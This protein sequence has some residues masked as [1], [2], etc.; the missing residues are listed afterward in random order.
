[1]KNATL[2][3]TLTPELRRFVEGKV[4][5]GR[6][7]DA[8]EVIR[9][10]LRKFEQGSDHCEDPS[11]EKLIKEGLDSG[12]AEPLNRRAWSQIWAESDRLARSLRIK[13]KRAAA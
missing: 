8:S 4:R 9:D 1:M 6:Y 3:V 2:Q 5:T 7:Q 13:P 11:L 12:P 10:A